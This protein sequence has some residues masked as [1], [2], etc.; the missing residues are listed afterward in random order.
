LPLKSINCVTNIM[1]KPWVVGFIEAEGSFY[2]TFHDSS[3][4]VH[5]FGLTQKLDSIVLESIGLILHIPNSVKYK[6]MQNYYI[7]DTTNSRA[8]ENIIYYFKNTMKGV[9]SL[10]YKIWARSYTKYKGNYKKLFSIRDIIRKIR[11]LLLEI[12]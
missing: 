7:L 12:T 2:L 1:T 3:R 6:E 10:E 9:K 5:G 11:K 4:I 8:I